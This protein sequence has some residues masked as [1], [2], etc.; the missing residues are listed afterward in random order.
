MFELSSEVWFPVVSVLIGF[1]G[2]GVLDYFADARKAKAEATARNEARHQA[3]ALGKVAFQKEAL[4][5]L[6]ELLESLGRNLGRTHYEDVKASRETGK[7]RKNLLGEPL[8]TDLT[9]T[10][11]RVMIL[12]SRVSD[13]EVR[14]GVRSFRTGIARFFMATTERDAEIALDSLVSLSF[15][16]HESI[17]KSIREL[18]ERAL[19]LKE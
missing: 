4:V 5:E 2:K 15:V 12:G 18:E 19:A 13:D 14:E 16:L 1:V 7:W 8:N 9:K 17:G 10:Q 6:Q 3:V 11:S